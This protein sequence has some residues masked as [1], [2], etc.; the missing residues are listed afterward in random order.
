LQRTIEPCK[1]L[2]A[3]SKAASQCRDVD[4]FS[5]T[6]SAKSFREK[7]TKIKFHEI[8]PQQNNNVFHGWILP[9]GGF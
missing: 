4:L 7:F 8:F 5:T 3:P 6:L 1:K 9:V 2:K